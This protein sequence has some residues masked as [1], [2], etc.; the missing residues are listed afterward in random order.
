MLKK[1]KNVEFCPIFCTLKCYQDPFFALITVKKHII[2]LFLCIV[3]FAKAQYSFVLPEGKDKITV[4]FKLLNNLVLIPVEVNG[5][6]MSFLLDSGVN[7]PIMFSL[8]AGDS[9][10]V[11]SSSGSNGYCFNCSK[12]SEQN[13]LFCQVYMLCKNSFTADTTS[14]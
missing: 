8:N 10:S 12:I 3:G 6:E 2:L 9:L 14:S 1:A 4:P 7:K 11:F 5:V 13:E